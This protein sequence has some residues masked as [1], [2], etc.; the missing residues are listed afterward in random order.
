MGVFHI[1]NPHLAFI[2]HDIGCVEIAVDETLV[3]FHINIAQFQQFNPNVPFFPKHI[4]RRPMQRIRFDKL[5]VGAINQ[6]I[7]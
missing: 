5:E 4:R 7:P 1:K 6:R 2:N 3:F